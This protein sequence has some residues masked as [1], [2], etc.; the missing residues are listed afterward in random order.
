MRKYESI[1]IA[2]P[3]LSEEERQPLLDKLDN[4]ISKGQGLLVKMNEWGQ[5]RLAYEVKKQTRGYYVQMEF[6]GDGILV[7]ELERNMR[8]DDRVLKYMTVLVDA[9][10]DVE[11]VKAELEAA[12]ELEAAEKKESQPEPAEEKAES[13]K[14]ADA[15]AEPAKGAEPEDQALEESPAESQEEGPADG[16]L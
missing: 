8:L 16:V 3:D 14:G 13:D 11:A 4:L 6:C 2:N 9:E 10:V 15:E 7:M 5:K 1:F 12:K